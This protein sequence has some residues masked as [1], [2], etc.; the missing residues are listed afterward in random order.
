M[1]FENK[2]YLLANPFRNNKG[3]AM[4]INFHDR[5][6]YLVGLYLAWNHFQDPQKFL[7]DIA[8]DFGQLTLFT[9]FEG[10]VPGLVCK[11][12][13]TAPSL[14][15]VPKEFPA[16]DTLRENF[17]EMKN[18]NPVPFLALNYDLGEKIWDYKAITCP[19]IDSSYSFT[20]N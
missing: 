19:S 10:L 17:L 2:I 8:S 7:Q 20:P 12:S 15:S 14:I 16:Y 4:G 18:S 6:D 13:I 9:P 3:E 1:N 5:S 11:M